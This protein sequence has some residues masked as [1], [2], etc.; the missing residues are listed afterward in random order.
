MRIHG[1]VK[2]EKMTW[3]LIVEENSKLRDVLDKLGE[4]TDEYRAKD[5]FGFRSYDNT[6]SRSQS[7]FG[8]ESANGLKEL[9]HYKTMVNSNIFNINTEVRKSTHQRTRSSQQCN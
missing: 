3:R 9:L 4:Y 7:A 1:Y 2:N 6:P 8:L 5:S